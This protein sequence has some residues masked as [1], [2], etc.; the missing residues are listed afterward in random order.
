MDRHEFLTGLHAALRP[1]SYLEIG[2]N[3]GRGLARSSTR[4][5]GVDPDFRINAELACDLKL[6]RKTSDDFF[7]TPG[8]LDWFPG[9]SVDLTFIDGMHL[10]EFALR[11]FINAERVSAPTSVIVF[12]DMLPRRTEEAA[13][14]RKVKFWAGDVFKVAGVLESHRPDLVVIPIDTQPTGLLLVANVDPS[15]TVLRDAYD[16]VLRDLLVGDP[17]QIPDNVLY[18]RTAAEPQQ[19]L[20]SPVWSELVAARGGP[21]PTSVESLRALRGSAEYASD[22]PEPVPWPPPKKPA[23]S[24]KPAVA[25]PAQPRSLSKRLRN[26]LARRIAG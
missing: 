24:S 20:D 16:A 9:G 14:D 3:D 21:V 4:S 6:V 8:A 22:P 5:I 17:Q 26:G 2:V 7:A 1:R 18:R 13:R 19:L 25:R 23:T 12:D 11:D 10:S 15:S